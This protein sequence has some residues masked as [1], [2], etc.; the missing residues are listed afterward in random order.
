MLF[1]SREVEEIPGVH[2]G[3]GEVVA[4]RLERELV[5]LTS[6]GDRFVLCAA[7]HVQP[8]TRC[9]KEQKDGEKMTR[10]PIHA[11]LECSPFQ[12]I[13]KPMVEK[14]RECSRKRIRAIP[15]LGS[16]DSRNLFAAGNAEFQGL[17]G[18]RSLWGQSIFDRCGSARS[19]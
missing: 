15:G 16:G 7:F 1:R 12:A 9:A 11:S 19:S 2:D 4:Y 18:C 5:P 10:R 17:E 8:K 6:D 3:T 13:I 14:D